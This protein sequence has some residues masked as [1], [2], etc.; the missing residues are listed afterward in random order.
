M[1]NSRYLKAYNYVKESGEGVDRMYRELSSIG[2][3]E[4][5]SHVESFITK[6]LICAHPFKG[7][8]AQGQEK[9]KKRVK[10]YKKESMQVF[11]LKSR[12]IRE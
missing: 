6:A 12:I 4:P 9:G 1:A 7:A 11:L 2:V 3:D 8:S 10:K 5:K